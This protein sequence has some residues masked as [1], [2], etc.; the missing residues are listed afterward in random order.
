[1]EYGGSRRAAQPS[2]AT[3]GPLASLRAFTFPV[4]RTGK[5]ISSVLGRTVISRRR[6]DG[7]SSGY[8]EAVTLAYGET[9]PKFERE[10]AR[11]SIKPV[12]G[13]HETPSDE[14]GGHA[15]RDGADS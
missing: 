8:C 15:H 12:S 10:A 4:Q 9:W 7:A 3:D 11:E 13:R 1:M 5:A 14:Y 6:R 2:E